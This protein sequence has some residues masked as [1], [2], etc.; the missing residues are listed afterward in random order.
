MNGSEEPQRVRVYSYQ[1]VWN[2]E[3]K[4]Y[5]IQNITL[6]VPVNPYEFLEFLSLALLMMVLGR[7]FP[8]INHIPTL[9]RYLLFPYIVVKY[10]MKLKLDGKNPMKYLVGL[11]PYVF[12]KHRYLEKFRSYDQGSYKVKF[13]WN[14]SKGL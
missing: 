4:I 3:K 7:I 5:A 1:K 10:L 6:P 12:A 8:V 11:I 2:I 9:L 13:Q 14:C